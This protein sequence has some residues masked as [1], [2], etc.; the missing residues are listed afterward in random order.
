MTEKKLSANRRNSLKSTGPKSVS[1]KARSSRNALKHG[2]TS[3]APII[4]GLESPKEWK[5]HRDRLFKSIAPFDYVQE[6]LTVQL[7]NTWWRL[8]RVSRYE[9]AVSA[10]AIAGAEVDLD[11][12]KPSG[13]SEYRDIAQRASLVIDTLEALPKLSVETI[14]DADSA[15]F[16]FTA[17]CESAPDTEEVISFP[18]IFNSPPGSEVEFTAKQWTVG[19]VRNVAE[20]LAASGRIT[21]GDLLYKSLK[22]AYRDRRGAEANERRLV[23]E[24]RRWN[25]R[26]ER[27]KTTRTLLGP[28]VLKN[29]ARYETN[30]WGTA[31]RLLHE[32]QRREAAR[33]GAIVPPPAALDVDLTIHPQSPG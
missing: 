3:E 15:T 21:V 22:S 7:A 30:L 16:A 33:S 19:L 14:L 2:L 9:A 17:L 24:R 29:L 31:F 1:G 26:L 27:E 18:G 5:R 8:A 28:D 4:L 6:M 10:A 25:L 20:R 11:D 23:E 13:T 12:E 32:I